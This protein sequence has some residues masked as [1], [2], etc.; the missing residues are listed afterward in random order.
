[1]IVVDASALAAFILKEP[2][3]RALSRYLKL[4]ISVDHVVKE[5]L[6]A[7]WKT[8]TLRLIDT[9]DAAQLFRILMSMIGVNILL[10]PEIRYLDRAF[11]IALD[12]RITI[13]D[14]LYIAL[15]IE[16]KLP[17]LTLD[18][19]QGNVARTLGVKTVKP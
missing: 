2:G 10:E 17:L 1:M 13:Y 16:K 4:G 18:E 19:K 8:H 14:A 12:N 15:A 7:V 3:W 6:N 11:R 5:V 9:Q